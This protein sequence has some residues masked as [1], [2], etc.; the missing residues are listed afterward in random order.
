MSLLLSIVAWVLMS[1]DVSAAV[2]PP[3]MKHQCTQ[4]A[5][6]KIICSCR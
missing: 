3:V 6:G 1:T 2:C 5:K 4:G